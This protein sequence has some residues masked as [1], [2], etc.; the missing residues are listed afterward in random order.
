MYS[1]S[2]YSSSSGTARGAGAGVVTTASISASIISPMRALIW[3]ARPT[4]PAG[5]TK[6]RW[7]V[8][9]RA[10]NGVV[11]LD[12]EPACLDGETLDSGIPRG[13]GDMLVLS[14]NALRAREGSPRLKGETPPPLLGESAADLLGEMPAA[15]DG[16]LRGSKF[17]R[18]ES[19]ASAKRRQHGATRACHVT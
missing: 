8:K 19:M 2:G 9:G 1:T 3:P 11:P 15:L 10:V 4:L 14:V 13:D 7:R 6:L 16:E 17:S 5:V 18:A 12:G